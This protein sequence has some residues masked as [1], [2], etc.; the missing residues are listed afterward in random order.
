MKNTARFIMYALVLVVAISSL[1]NYGFR[2]FSLPQHFQSHSV[3]IF[4]THVFAAVVAL[5]LGP[6]QFSARLRQRRRQL[7]RW[8]GRLYLGVGVLFGGLSGLAMACSSS[9]SLAARIGF[10]ALALTWLYSGFKAYQTI[11]AGDVEQHRSY[12]VRNFSLTLA[13]VTL[14]VYLPL[15]MMSG[16]DFTTAYAVIAWMCWVPN[17]LLAELLWN[18]RPEQ[19]KVDHARLV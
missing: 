4:Y 7:H 13:A 16:A 3:G 19:M 18:R 12:M 2:G 9:N 14:R 1:Y 17:L 10:A 6:L 15:S 5:L 8:L 11:R